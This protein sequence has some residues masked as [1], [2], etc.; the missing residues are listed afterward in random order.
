M[1]SATVRSTR[2]Q[3]VSQDPRGAE[4]PAKGGRPA[5]GGP[6]FAARR[7]VLV[8]LILC[9]LVGLA[10]GANYGPLRHYLDAR[11]RLEKRTAEVA[12]LEKRNAEMQTQLSKLLQPGYLEQLARQQLTYSRPDEDLYIV[13]GTQAE[14]TNTTLAGFAGIGGA[15]FASDSPGTTTPTTDSSASEQHPG[16]LERLLSRIASLF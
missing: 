16:F 8:I 5:K 14:R 1:A 6:H 13:A 9:G 3:P 11:A 2:S 4:D 7:R 10:A 15:T 12:A